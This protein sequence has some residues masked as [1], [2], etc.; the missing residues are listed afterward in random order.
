MLHDAKDLFNKGN[1]FSAI[2]LAAAAS[3]VLCQLCEIYNKENPHQD[4]KDML[5]DFYDSNPDFFSKPKKALKSFYSTKNA[6][7]HLNSEQD[8]YLII[9]PKMRAVLFIN[10]ASKAA[11]A[12]GIKNELQIEL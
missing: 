10:Q 6:I 2:N 9:N 12:L 1:F 11:T 7:K 5:K 8:Q 3:E 4:L